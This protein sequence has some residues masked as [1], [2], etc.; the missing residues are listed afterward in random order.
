MQSR[1]THGHVPIALAAA[2]SRR[3]ASRARL[4]LGS[5]AGAKPAIHQYTS[6]DI[7]TGSRLYSGQCMT[8]HG[9]NGDTVSGINLR[10]GQFRRPMSDDDL[11]H[12][13]T[14]G[15]P[16]TGMPPFAFQAT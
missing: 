12:T 9:A 2:V 4:L 5:L 16:G 14:T 13:I 11:R 10:R 6:Q 8:C 3:G 1:I 15:V 7:E